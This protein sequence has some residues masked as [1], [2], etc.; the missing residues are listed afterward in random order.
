[1]SLGRDEAGL[2]IV[3]A[4]GIFTRSIVGIVAALHVYHGRQRRSKSPAFGIQVMKS[5]FMVMEIPTFVPIIACATV[6]VVP[7]RA[8]TLALG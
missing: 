3:S 8:L 2:S 6:G 1:M 4:I 5:R 7:A